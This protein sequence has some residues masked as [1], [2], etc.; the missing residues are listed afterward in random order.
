[1]NKNKNLYFIFYFIIYFIIL[2][3][4]VSSF[5]TLFNYYYYFFFRENFINNEK[6]IILLGDSMLN[7]VNYLPLNQSIP[8]LL[9]R[10][11]S[12]VFVFAEDNAT[13]NSV[14]FQL[15]EISIDYNNKNTF[16]FLSIGGNDLLKNKNNKENI[17]KKY[18]LLIDSIL[19]KMPN[20]NLILLTLYY[21]FND[22][23][24]KYHNVISWWNNQIFNNYSKKNIIITSKFMNSS[25]DFIF[26]I[27]PSFLGGN[28]IINEI[29]KKII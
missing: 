29:K 14:Y 20:I 4:F 3:I 28:K 17:F 9:K 7:N 27:E 1:M 18:K 11:N 6:T 19:S 2:I 5:S 22:D 12:S 26:N 21:P 25:S 15:N 8:F 16:I 10:E 24:N 13:I 23:F